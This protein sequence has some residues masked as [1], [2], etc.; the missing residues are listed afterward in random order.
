M[1][2]ISLQMIPLLT[3]IVS[4][5][6]ESSHIKQAFEAEYPKLLRMSADLWSKLQQF[7]QEISAA[8]NAANLANDEYLAEEQ[9]TAASN[10]FK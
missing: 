3:H 1:I 6:S 7:H 10:Q 2:Y 4:R 5:W 8:S 9:N